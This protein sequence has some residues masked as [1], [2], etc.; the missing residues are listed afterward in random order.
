MSLSVKDG[1]IL[2]CIFNWPFL[3]RRVA[4]QLDMKTQNVGRYSTDLERYAQKW[5]TERGYGLK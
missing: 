4:I 5:L 1:Q 3:A 2:I